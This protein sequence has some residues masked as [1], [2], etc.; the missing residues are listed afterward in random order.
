MLKK[1]QEDNLVQEF[2]VAD[3]FVHLITLHIYPSPHSQPGGRVKAV[4][5]TMFWRLEVF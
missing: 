4:S 5:G 2:S 3:V 1:E